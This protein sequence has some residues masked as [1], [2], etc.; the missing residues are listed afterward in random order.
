M[1]LASNSIARL[2]KEIPQSQTAVLTN[3]YD[4]KL[5]HYLWHVGL[6]GLSGVLI[7][8]QHI[9]PLTHPFAGGYVIFGGII[10]GLTCFVDI[11]E[12]ATV[13]LSFPWLL[14]VVL[15]G[16][17]SGK[18]QRQRGIK[19]QPI[20]TFFL[21]AYLLAMLLLLAWGWYWG[22]FPEFSQLGIID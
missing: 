20:L 2:A 1:H 13:Y 14:A 16:L 10:H 19:R 21:T 7:Y 6:F 8:R 18:K 12:S 11:V 22:G 5:S 9:S 15:F 3:F 17:F 4:E